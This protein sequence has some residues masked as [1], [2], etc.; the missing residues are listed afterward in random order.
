MNTQQIPVIYAD[1]GNKMVLSDPNS[2]ESIIKRAK[3]QE[4]QSGAD[5]KYDA[6]PPPRLENF[7]DVTIVWTNNIH[8]KEVTLGLFLASAVLLLL[9]AA[10]PE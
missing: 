1:A 5:T 8:E 4:A 10:A 3:E 6:T 2:P 7:Q 9:Y